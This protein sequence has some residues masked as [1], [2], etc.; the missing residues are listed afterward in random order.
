[1]GAATQAKMTVGITTLRK[2]TF[3]ILTLGVKAKAYLSEAAF[4]CSTL[5]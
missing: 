2:M 3:S 5:G 1:M 4:R